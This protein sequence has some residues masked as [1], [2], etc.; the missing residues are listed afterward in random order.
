MVV[1]PSA[2]LALER[3][4]VEFDRGDAR[5]P[6]LSCHATQSQQSLLKAIASLQQHCLPAQFSGYFFSSQKPPATRN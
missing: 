4:L 1:A 6:S 2:V 3:E 5:T